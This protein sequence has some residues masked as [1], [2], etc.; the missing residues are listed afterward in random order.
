MVTNTLTLVNHASILI[1]GKK[2]AILTD[3]WYEGEVLHKGWRLLHENTEKEIECILNDTT[4]IWISREYPDHFSRD[5]F[6]KYQSAI[7]DRKIPVMFRHTK[8]KRV[9]NFLKHAGFHGM[10]VATEEPLTLEDRFT[11]RVIKDGRYDSALLVNVAGMDIFNVNDWPMDSEKRIKAFEKRYGHCDVLLAAFSYATGRGGP[12]DV[13]GRRAAAEAQLMSLVRQG[14][15]LQAKTVIPIG[16]FMYFANVLNSYMN[17]AV[18]TPRRVKDACRAAGA[19]FKCVFLKP[20]ETLD[21]DNDSPKQ[22][23]SS[24]SFWEHAFTSAKPYIRYQNSHSIDHLSELFHTYCDRLRNTNSWWRVWLCRCLGI[25]FKP[26]IVKLLDTGDVVCLNLARRLIVPSR[27]PPEIALHSES[28]AFMF[29][30][31][32]G[33]DT[34]AVNGTLQELQEGGLKTFSRTFAIESRNETGYRFKLVRAVFPAGEGEPRD[35]HQRQ[36]AASEI[37]RA[38][39]A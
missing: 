14:Q 31:P 32:Y 4:Y 34:L 38:R 3:P 36:P 7:I 9:I 30:S 13:H 24:L 6:R 17:D 35:G 22:Q 11:V 26:V 19:D 10:E 16:S 29:K 23:E 2:H 15:R 27:R 33:F 25:A 12:E 21:L 8:D 20:M 39:A 5:F 37:S 18:M 1:K 28:L